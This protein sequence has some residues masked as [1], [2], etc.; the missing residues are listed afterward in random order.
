MVQDA[1]IYFL[2]EFDALS[3]HFLWSGNLRSN[4]QALAAKIYW[5]WCSG[6]HQLWAHIITHK[7][8]YGADPCS[9]STLPVQ[10][11][12]SLVWH[13]LKIGAMLVKRGLF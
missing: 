1:P 8:F 11:C 6:Q 9:L 2:K 13:T 4:S 12:G 5:R 7:Y 10:G 3:Q